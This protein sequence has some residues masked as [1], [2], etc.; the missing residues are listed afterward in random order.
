MARG[1]D[2]H[3]A[4]LQELAGLGRQLSRRASSKCELC[5]GSD[6]NRP[7]E[8]EPTFDHPDPD[9]AILACARCRG[10]AEAKKIARDEQQLRFL[11]Q[12]MWSETLPAQL[13]AVRLLRKLKDADVAWAGDALDGLWLPDDVSALL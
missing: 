7:V 8:V 12:S 3:K 13:M 2:Q 4:H 10:L 6:D 1:R 9:R 5:E 11:E